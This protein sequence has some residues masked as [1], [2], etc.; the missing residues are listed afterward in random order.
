MQAKN[1]SHTETGPWTA[2]SFESTARRSY[3]FGRAE[4]TSDHLLC[5]SLLVY[6][7]LAVQVMLQYALLA[8]QDDGLL[9]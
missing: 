6:K 1:S 7:L 2:S 3:S 9:P 4:T 8:M 5:L